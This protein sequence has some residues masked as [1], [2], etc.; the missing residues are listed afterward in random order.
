[1]SS[2]ITVFLGFYVFW[3]KRPHHRMT[4][5]WPF[6]ILVAKL[7]PFPAWTTGIPMLLLFFSVFFSTIVCCQSDCNVQI[8]FQSIKPDMLEVGCHNIPLCVPI[9]LRK[10]VPGFL[11]GTAQR[12]YL[13]PAIQVDCLWQSAPIPRLR[14]LLWYPLQA[15]GWAVNGVCLPD[16]GFIYEH[17]PRW[18]SSPCEF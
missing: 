9:L 3:I 18:W 6:L 11:W 1:M 15:R 4:R 2:W 5:P 16:L 17:G 7:P 12:P 14:H 13:V 8:D 10:S